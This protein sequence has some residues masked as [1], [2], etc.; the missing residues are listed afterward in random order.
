MPLQPQAQ[1]QAE[2]PHLLSTIYIQPSPS[3]PPV[4][5]HVPT[6]P[7]PS[8]QPSISNAG[9]VHRPGMPV[10]PVVVVLSGAPTDA[11]IVMTLFGMTLVCCRL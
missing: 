4:I 2:L 7:R 6:S 10:T 1:P 9:T 3:Q 8:Y 5:H 11:P